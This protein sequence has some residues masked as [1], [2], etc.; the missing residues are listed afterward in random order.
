MRLL[1]NGGDSVKVRVNAPKEVTVCRKEI[2]D[3]NLRRNKAAADVRDRRGLQL[4][5]RK[6]LH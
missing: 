1:Q 6:R 3:E 4:I 2:Y 5:L